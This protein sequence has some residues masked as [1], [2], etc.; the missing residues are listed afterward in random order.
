MEYERDETKLELLKQ[1][2][3]QI[4]YKLEELQR[5]EEISEYSRCTII[6]M[7]NKVLEHIAKR[8]DSVR[9]GVKSVMGGK[10]LEYEAKTIR[11]EGRAVGREE[12]RE[13][14]RILTVRIFQEAKRNPDA[15]IEQI[16]EKV[17]CEVREVADILRMFDM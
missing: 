17:G 8:Y 9:K 13:E 16:A 12:G 1:E 4:K 14:G 5:Q 11:E 2:Y 7:S 10:V 3:E 15:T 6:D